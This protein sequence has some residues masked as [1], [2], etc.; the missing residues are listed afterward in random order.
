LGG[1]ENAGV[2][3]SINLI[4]D[5]SH[6]SLTFIASFN[7]NQSDSSSEKKTGFETKSNLRLN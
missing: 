5:N 3:L 7:L 2:I 4:M 1:G 6:P